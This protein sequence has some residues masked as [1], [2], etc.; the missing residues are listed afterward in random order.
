MVRRKNPLAVARLRW[1]YFRPDLSRRVRFVHGRREERVEAVNILDIEANRGN[2]GDDLAKLELVEDSRLS[3]EKQ[4]KSIASLANNH[5]H[6][7]AAARA[8]VRVQIKTHLA[9]RVEANHEDAH[10]LLS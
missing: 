10:I 2:S 5:T 4:C 9:C 8:P 7:F 1:Q 3:R 6:I